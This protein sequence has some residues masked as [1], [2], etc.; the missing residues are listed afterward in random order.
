MHFYYVYLML[1]IRRLS[2]QQPMILIFCTFFLTF[3]THEA[4][5]IN[6][7]AIQFSKILSFSF[8]LSISYYNFGIVS[9]PLLFLMFQ[10]LFCNLFSIFN[11][12]P[13]CCFHEEI[14]FKYLVSNFKLY[15]FVR[16]ILMFTYVKLKRKY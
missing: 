16:L 8:F 14:S 13:L 15:I 11:L 2:Y 10:F 12:F 7:I 9:F 3:V 1:V 4:I 6:C 5:N